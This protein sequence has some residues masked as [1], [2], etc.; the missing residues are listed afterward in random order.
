MILLK[1]PLV[2]HDK[3]LIRIFRVIEKDEPS[4]WAPYDRW[5]KAH[6]M[7][8]PKWWERAIDSFIHSE[9]LVPQAAVPLLQSVPEAPDRLGGRARPRRTARLADTGRGLTRSCGFS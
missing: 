6:G 1:H 9:L 7:R 8:D 2:K 5:I 3:T 4:H